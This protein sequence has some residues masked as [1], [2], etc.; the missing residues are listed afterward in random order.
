MA[1]MPVQVVFCPGRRGPAAG[2]ADAP[3]HCVEPGRTQ[4]RLLLRSA[5]A[6]PLPP[7]VVARLCFPVRGLRFSSH[8]VSRDRYQSTPA[9]KALA[10][11]Q[12]PLHLFCAAS[13]CRASI[14]ACRACNIS[15]SLW[16]ITN[17]VIGKPGGE[18][19]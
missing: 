11:E 18:I 19:G 2:V 8:S 4:F 13:A 6:Q 5:L 12:F 15:G 14:Y 7:R 9:A 3:H 1:A 10:W 16:A 17:R